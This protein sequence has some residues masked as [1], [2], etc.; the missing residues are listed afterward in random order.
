MEIAVL[1]AGVIGISTAYELACRG[2]NVSVIDQNTGPALETSFGN[3]G[4]IAT[5]HA[6]SWNSPKL[7][8]NLLKPNSKVKSTF[9]INWSLSP[10]LYKWG[11]QFLLNCS[12]KKFIEFSNSKREL[13]YYSYN[14]LKQIIEKENINC[15][16]NEN[17]IYYLYRTE[18]GL[19]NSINKIKLFKGLLEQYQIL[20][21]SDLSHNFFNNDKFK[22]SLIFPNDG[23]G[24][25]NLF[26]TSL[27]NKCK[28]LGVKF[29]YNSKVN[30]F[31][32]KN[33]KID[34]IKMNKNEFKSDKF[35]ISFGPYSSIFQKQLKLSIPIY[36]V[37]GYSLT[38]P[39]IDDSKI[40]D[41]SGID[42]DNFLAFSK[43]G[44][45]MRI[46]SIAE[47]AG[48]DKS[49]NPKIVNKLIA[50]TK[51][52]FGDSLDYSNCVPWTGFRPVTPKGTP[53]ICK[54]KIQNLYL[55]TGHGHLGWSMASGSAHI[56]SDIIENKTPKINPLPYIV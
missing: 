11:I 28:K 23:S 6:F 43:F 15:H 32:I 17:G 9:K 49:L 19:N 25:C 44:D 40:P 41:K 34:S 4:L 13:C 54:T 53:Y 21:K 42:E 30:E 46:T 31:I 55:N 20:N 10:E 52:L 47:F 18:E 35:I 38:L 16:Y 3:A 33:K 39:I 51:E 22:T 27:E 5:G 45:K 37:K 1:G 14:L 12:N 7:L 8:T 56:I 48:F 24:D 29:L 36:P 26:T 50:L 2:H